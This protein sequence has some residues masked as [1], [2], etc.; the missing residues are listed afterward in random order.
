M[1][2]A[3]NPTVVYGSKTLEFVDRILNRIGCLILNLSFH[4]HQMFDGKI[5]R[6]A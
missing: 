5:I 3:T 6:T 2:S 1:Q 4:P